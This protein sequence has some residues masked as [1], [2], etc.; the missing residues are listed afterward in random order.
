MIAPAIFFS[1]NRE[2]YFNT[3]KNIEQCVD[4]IPY[5]HKIL[6]G[7]ALC[8]VRN[9]MNSVRRRKSAIAD[10]QELLPAISRRCAGCRQLEFIFN[11]IH[12]WLLM[13]LGCVPRARVRK[14][15]FN[16]FCVD[17]NR[18]QAFTSGF[19]LTRSQ[20]SCQRGLVPSA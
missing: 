3:L 4:A 12:R 16:Q 7:V 2:I 15:S 9:R 5:A 6:S 14:T 8:N 1:N 19:E 11:C 13:P 10:N 17:L 18:P 20:I